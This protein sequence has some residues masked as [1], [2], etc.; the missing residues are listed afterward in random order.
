MKAR[1]TSSALAPTVWRTCRVL[2]NRMRLRIFRQMVLAGH[3]SVKQVA[4]RMRLAPSTATAYLRQLNARGFL[5]VD[6]VGRFAIYRAKPDPLLPQ[7]RIL[8]QCMRDAALQKPAEMEK[9]YRLLTAF[10]HPRRIRIVECLACEEMTQ[11]ELRK[12]AQIPTMALERHLRKLI[13][14]GYV[15]K[16]GRHYRLADNLSDFAKGLLATALQRGT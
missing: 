7:F 2:A 13:N 14:R 3:S 5:A 4:E 1:G 6:R 12:A 9:V 11:P 16:H 8:F 10:T 15:Q